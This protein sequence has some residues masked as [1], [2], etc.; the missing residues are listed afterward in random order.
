[1]WLAPHPSGRSRWWNKAEHQRQA[2]V[3]YSRILG[4]LEFPGDP[5]LPSVLPPDNW[6]ALADT[7]AWPRSA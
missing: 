4:L 3:F 2:E 5:A 6:E 7:R 1:V